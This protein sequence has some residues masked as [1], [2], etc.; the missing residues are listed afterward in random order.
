MEG[1]TVL[2]SGTIA[3]RLVDTAL[4]AMRGLNYELNIFQ[5]HKLSDC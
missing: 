5:N 1:Q 4:A 2:W 3:K